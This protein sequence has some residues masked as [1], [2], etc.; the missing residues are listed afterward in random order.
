MLVAGQDFNNAL[1]AD[2]VPA[3]IFDDTEPTHSKLK[4]NE[5]FLH[6][7]NHDFI[8]LPT[9]ITTLGLKNHPILPTAR[10]PCDFWL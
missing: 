9:N 2:T 1:S 4:A 6:L 8:S 7:D 10:T 3:S 5:T